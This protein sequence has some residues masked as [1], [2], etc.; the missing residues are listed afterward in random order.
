MLFLKRLFSMLLFVVTISHSLADAS[1]TIV[2]TD[3]E[4]NTAAE[5]KIYLDKITGDNFTIVDEKNFDNSHP[6]IYLGNTV[7]A[8]KNGIDSGKF[9]AEEWLIKSEGKNLIITGGRLNGTLYGV[10]DFLENQLGCHW[11]S[12]D[13]EFI[14]KKKD[15]DFSGLNIR[16]Q[17]SFVERTIYIPQWGLGLNKENSQ[18][19]SLFLKRNGSNM[20]SGPMRAS[21]GLPNCHNLYSYVSPE[22]YFAE[23]PEYFSMNEKGRR[24]HGAAKNRSGGQLCMSNP[25]VWK[26][27]LESL[28]EFIKKDR[29][30]L[31][32]EKWPTLY[33]IS[34][35]DDTNFICK[36]PECLKITEQ[37]GSE[38]GLLLTYINYVAKNIAKEYPELRILTE[39]YVHTEKAPLIIKPEPNVIMRWCDLYTKSDCYRPLTSKFNEA[40]KSQLEGWKKLG[41]NMAVWDYWNM[42]IEGQYFEPPRVEVMVDAIAPDLRY[43]KE[44]GVTMMFMEAEYCI[45]NPQNFIDLQYWLGLQLALDTNKDPEKLIECYMNNHYGPAAVTMTELLNYIRDAVRN[46]TKPLFYIFNPVRE[47]TNANFLKK[48]YDYLRKAQS[49]TS[50]NSLYRVRVDKEMIT[51]ICVILQNPQFKTGLD[52]NKLVEEYKKYRTEQIDT[53]CSPEKQ[54]E[55]KKR[56]ENQITKLT[57]EI[58]TPSQFADI[59]VENIKKFAWPHVRSG[60]VIDDPESVTGKALVSPPKKEHDMSKPGAGSLY[61]TWFGLYDGQSKRSSSPLKLNDI[62]QDEKYHW[63]KVDSFDFGQDTFL[64]GF[65]WLNSV[66]LSSVYTNADGLPGFNTWE[67]WVSVK[68]TGPVYVKESRKENCIYLDQIILIKPNTSGN[69]I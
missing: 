20:Y 32:P 51:P 41:A 35:L 29:T 69:K 18:K 54:Q 23:H 4:K 14:P 59:P 28:R 57:L 30:T 33:V 63:Y 9:Q 27:T 34:Q 2:T 42:G 12:L 68:V 61:P 58:P 67:V 44:T 3:A 22:K 55:F 16:K 19:I 26:I 11:F 36:C 53:Y 24:F 38:A 15:L 60:I 52:K 25:E 62:P 6:A 1:R 50:E 64:W 13:S 8:E 46:E 66:T 10:Y 56:I 48:C 39:A 17:P 49:E 47:Y 7:F 37:E 40:R 21:P 5:L 65:F 31:Q 43:F 45:D